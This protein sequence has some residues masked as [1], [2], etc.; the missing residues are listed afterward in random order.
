MISF[1]IDDIIAKFGP[2]AL[3]SM[4]KLPKQ[5]SYEAKATTEKLVGMLDDFSYDLPKNDAS[6]PIKTN[7][8]VK[9]YRISTVIFDEL[10]TKFNRRRKERV[11]LDIRFLS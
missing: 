4:L 8:K 3:R 1:L 10:V 6:E 2:V 9:K 11:V 5:K 7:T